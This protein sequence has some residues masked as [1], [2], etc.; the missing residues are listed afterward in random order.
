VII[1]TEDQEHADVEVSAAE[2]AKAQTDVVDVLQRLREHQDSQRAMNDRLNAIGAAL[3]RQINAAADMATR[4]M[5]RRACRV[6]YD[7]EAGEV[8]LAIEIDPSQPV[9]RRPMNQ[10]ERALAEAV[11][12]RRNP[13][14][15]PPGHGGI[16]AD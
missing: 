15:Q 13:I 6:G 10:A 4:S 16:D 5:A 3:T 1:W 7:L 9:I 14:S 11:A 12:A 8:V 2:R